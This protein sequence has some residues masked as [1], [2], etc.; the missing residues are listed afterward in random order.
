MPPKIKMPAIVKSHY[1]APKMKLNQQVFNAQQMIGKQTF[2]REQVRRFAT[3]A[4]NNIKKAKTA[5]QTVKMSVVIYYDKKEDLARGGFFDV[6]TVKTPYLFDAEGDYE[7]FPAI[8]TQ[9]YHKFVIFYCVQNGAGGCDDGT[10]DC[11]YERLEQLNCKP[12]DT[13]TDLKKFLKIGRKDLVSIDHIKKIEASTY[14]K[15]YKINVSGDVQYVSM[16]KANR[17]INLLLKDEHYNID[18][19]IHKIRYKGKH[20]LLNNK[21]KQILVHGKKKDNLFLCYNG[22]KE[23]TITAEEMK[24]INSTHVEDVNNPLTRYVPF[25]FEANKEKGITTLETYYRYMMDA[26]KQLTTATKGIVNLKRSKTVA[27]AAFEV[28]DRFQKT[29]FFDNVKQ[30]EQIAV[31]KATIGPLLY[32]KEYTGEAYK[33]DFTSWYPFIMSHPK[34]NIPFKEGEFRKLDLDLNDEATILSTGLYNCII[35]PNKDVLFRYNNKHDWYTQIDINSARKK[36]LS[37]EL[38]KEGEYN[39]YVYSGTVTG[40]QMFHDSIQYLFEHKKNKVPL[41]KNVLNAM[42]GGLCSANTVKMT[43]DTTQGDFVEKEG[44]ELVDIIEV[45][46][47]LHITMAR[48]HDYYKHG[49][50]RMKP[51]LLAKARAYFY[52]YI[53]QHVGFENVVRIHT[54]GFITTKKLNV[55][56]GE[57]LGQLK[58]EGYCDNC[59]VVNTMKVKGEFIL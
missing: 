59:T 30:F 36:G 16:K 50:A 23:F 35:T 32:A 25:E 22:K 52:E 37:V 26:C 48:T 38:C 55:D 54:D 47:E 34:F 13:P 42:W 17:E 33:Y 41:A 10:N 31:E 39:A 14:M 58:Y 15:G 19:D 46:N 29:I 18:R 56:I 4:M 11:F 1:K 27:K 6:D 45:N 24:T 8:D 51:F 57:E 49:E 7:N 40:H 53:D 28:Y 44:R 5:D 20:R 3:V 12:F 21:D 2:T 43:H 9:N